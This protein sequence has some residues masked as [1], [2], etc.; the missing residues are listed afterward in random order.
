MVGHHFA[1]FGGRRRFGSEDIMFLVVEEQDFTCPSLN[2]LI[3]FI[4]KGHD[5]LRLN[6]WNIIINKTM[7]KSCTVGRI[8]KVDPG[9]TFTG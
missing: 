1:K 9:H 5:M 6:T 3:L 2:L 4:S 7:T 8:K